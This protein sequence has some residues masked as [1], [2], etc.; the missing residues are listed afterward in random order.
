MTAGAEDSLTTAAGL[1]GVDREELRDSL[2]SRVMQATRGGTKGTAI[3]Y[4]VALV[5]V[6]PKSS[7]FRIW[8]PKCF[9]LFLNSKLL[10]QS[11]GM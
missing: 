2:T 9:T 10:S 3:K 8:I 5:D 7:F 1:L 4:V 6:D 11:C